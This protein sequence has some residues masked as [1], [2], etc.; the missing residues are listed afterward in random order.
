MHEQVQLSGFGAASA[1][2]SVSICVHPWF[3][4]LACG[5]WPAI[6]GTPPELGMVS[7]E[8]GVECVMGG[9][10]GQTGLAMALSPPGKGC[11]DGISGRNE[12]ESTRG[13]KDAAMATTIR[14]E[15]EIEIPLGL[16]SLEDFRRWA[17]SD[18]FP[19]QG[20]IDY[21]DGCIEVDMS[22][23]DLLTHGSLKAEIHAAVHQKVKRGRLGHVFVDRAR[24]SCPEADLSAEP[25]V[26]F[27]SFASRSS[28]RV[29]LVPKAGGKPGRF[30]EIEGPP[31]LVVE[32]VSDR[33]V[34]KDTRTLPEAY[35]KAGVGEYWLADARGEELLFR[36]HRLT[37]SGYQPA[38]PDAQ[39]FQPSAVLGCSFRLDAERD[40]QGEW[41]FDLLEKEGTGV[42]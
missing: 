21:L 27:V 18:E 34:T 25:D 5:N 9:C 2:S 33:S 11:C 41:R 30:I 17:R 3:P 12:G 20:R 38:T 10:Q 37:D 13:Q 6:E 36:I 8:I 22:P 15:E 23:E 35:A 7:C 39:G 24:V 14:L 28:G 19:Q 4:S 1:R 32:V 26:V 40:P 31:D 42:E 16:G 29:R